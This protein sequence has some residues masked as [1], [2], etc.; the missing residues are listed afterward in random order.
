MQASLSGE[1]RRMTETKW[2]EEEYHE[3]MNDASILLK[4]RTV[5]TTKILSNE[6]EISGRLAGILLRRLKWQFDKQTRSGARYRQ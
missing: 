4:E 3:M 5:T 1:E 6:M 2:T